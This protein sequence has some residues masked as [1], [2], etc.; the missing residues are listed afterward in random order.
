MILSSLTYHGLVLPSKAYLS[1][2]GEINVANVELD[3][4]DFVS[5]SGFIVGDVEFN[6]VSLSG[7]DY[8]YYIYFNELKVQ[9]YNVQLHDRRSKPDT[10][11]K[12]LIPPLTRVRITAL[13]VSDSSSNAQIVSFVGR[14]YG[15]E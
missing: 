10:W 6:M 9:G 12:I 7:D 13:N 2:S 1:F 8:V 11:I 4:L 15:A 14:V 3:L 5:S